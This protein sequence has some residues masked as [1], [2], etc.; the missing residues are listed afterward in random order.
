MHARIRICLGTLLGALLMSVAG[1]G[2]QASG[3]VLP[4]GDSNRGLTVF[5][6]LQCNQCHSIPDLI[7]KRYDSLYPDVEIVLGG[8]VSRVKSY[9]EL[10]T[11]VIHP[12]KEISRPVPDAALIDEDTSIMPNY[13]GAMTVAQ[14]VDLVTFLQDTYQLQL[15]PYAPY[16]MP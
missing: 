1:C 13:N 15:P 5:R 10:V 6:E 9:G 4:P 8:P 16:P 12:A 3:F 11:A 7:K 14:L 2:G